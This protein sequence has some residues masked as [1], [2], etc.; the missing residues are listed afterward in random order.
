MKDYSLQ[1]A[2]DAKKNHNIEE[3]T[4]DMNFTNFPGQKMPRTR[5]DT[6]V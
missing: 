6:E 1:S 4:Q 5:I 3:N 2:K